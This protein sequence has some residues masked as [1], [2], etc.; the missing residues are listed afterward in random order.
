MN[1]SVI[2]PLLLTYNEEANIDRTLRRLTW[3]ERVVLVD[4]YSEDATVHIATSYENVDLYQREFD[5]FADQCNFGLERIE[6]EWVLSLDA[7]YLCSTELI[8]EI[9]ALPESPSVDGFSAE[10]VYCI[11]GRPLRAT[12]YP[13][14]TVLYR[15][16]K[17]EYQRDG[18][19]HRVQ[20]EGPVGTLD[21]PI[22]HDDRKSLGRWLD[23]QREYAEREAEKL[24]DV[25]GGSLADRFRRTSVVAPL[26]VP[27]Y[28]LFGKGLILDGW[29]GWYY[30][31]QRTSAEILIALV[32]LD[33]KLR[34]YS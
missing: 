34:N 27:V 31:L 19:R 22:Y 1:A 8:S 3:A 6:T 28:C 11:F 29:A 9:Q 32:R 18:H 12:L 30:T 23:N 17:A 21:A 15:R 20:V 33:R 14:R 24:S 16:A 5:H 26:V 10:F 13:P 4:S 7:D 25:C 2:T